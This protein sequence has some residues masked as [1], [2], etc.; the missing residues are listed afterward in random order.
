MDL[1]TGG[2]YQGQDK[3]IK[4]NYNDSFE[5]Y[6]FVEEEYKKRVSEEDIISKA[7]LKAKNCEAVNALEIGAGMIPI[8]KEERNFREIYGRVVC[9]VA[10]ESDK[11]VRILCGLPTVIK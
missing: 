7:L 8:S 6:P 2:L 9:S 4:E 5:L 10:D 11:V 3:Y 1:I